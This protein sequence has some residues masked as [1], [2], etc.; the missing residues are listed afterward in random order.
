MQK[1]IAG[2]INELLGRESKEK[3]TGTIILLKE[4][5]TIM[6]TTE[7]KKNTEVILMEGNTAEGI[8]LQR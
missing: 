3:I 2:R 4:I 8:K 5:Q 6:I 7:V 1:D